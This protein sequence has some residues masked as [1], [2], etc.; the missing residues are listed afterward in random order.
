MPLKEYHHKRHFARTSEPRGKKHTK[1]GSSFVVQKHDASHLHYDFRLE[2]DGVLK[3]WAVPHGPCLDPSQKRL[4]VEVEDHPV[5]YGGFEGTIPAGE[6]G[7]GTV[8]LW[9]RGTWTPHGDPE[10]GYQSGKLKFE[11]H[12]E[13]LHGN[14]DL[15]RMRPR[16]GEKRTNWLLIKEQDSEAVPLA[17]ADILEE[18]PDS[19][20]S[21]RSL[22]QI[23]GSTSAK[24]A[25]RGRATKARPAAKAAS[26]ASQSRSKSTSST[27]KV[28]AG[29]K[30]PF[31]KTVEPELALLVKAPPE[32]SEWLH[33]AKFDGYRIICHLNQ[34][35]VVLRSRNQL[36]WTARFPEIA[37][38][39]QELPA[40]QAVLDGELVSLLPDGTSS[41]QELQMALTAKDTSH[42]KYYVFDLL[43]LDGHDL[44]GLP[45]DERRQALLDLIP[46]AH[47]HPLHFSKELKGT[48]AEAFR[49]ASERGFEGIVSKR[50]A[51]P[52]RSGRTG[53][54]LK[55]KGIQQDEFVIGGFTDSSSDRKELG[56]LLIG[57]YDGNGQFTYCGKVGTG[58][59][60][61]TLRDL[62]KLLA[63][64]E[65]KTNPFD[66]HEEMGS[67]RGVHWVKPTLVG[68]IGYSNWTRDGRL[69]QPVFQGLR[70]DK[71]ARTI[72]RDKPAATTKAAGPRSGEAIEGDSGLHQ[73]GKSNKAK[74]SASNED[75]NI[76]DLVNLTHP[77]RVLFPADG[78]TKLDLASYYAQIS[79][80]ILPHIENRPL[81]LLRCPEG[82]DGTCFYQKHA[83]QGTPMALRRIPI[84]EKHKTEYYLA[85]A[86]LSGLLSL[87]QMS[88]LEIHPWGSRV[89]DIERP[90]RIIFDLDPDP[91]VGWAEVVRA[92]RE[93]RD[94][95]QELRLVSF[96][97]TTGGKGLHVVV[98]LLRRHEW[99]EVKAFTKAVADQIVADS[100]DRYIATLSKAAR[101]GR[102][103]VDYLRNDRG[104]T[105]VAPYS[106]RAREGALVATP[107]SWNELSATTKPADFNVN[108]IPH[109]LASRSSDPW[110]EIG[111]IRQAL[112]APM[113]RKVGL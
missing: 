75:S 81:S 29:K 21:G 78:V 8:L 63:K 23:A 65:L 94:R 72:V 38:A 77:E 36:D 3:S 48:G 61:Q 49:Q 51:Q 85:V 62:H 17:E 33:E 100:P 110:Q 4:A 10:A 60:E 35:K 64:K 26:R 24:R 34:G 98:P 105:A 56:A 7:G 13:K 68:Q 44:R 59:S 66:N 53:D 70:E 31:L 39:V 2:L 42:L 83:G 58:Y 106:T 74:A 76:T 18:H 91:A 20:A 41:F 37:S 97:K 99:P 84:R 5:E 45:L 67:S 19:V 82:H 112:T 52:Y 46:N 43:Y 104:A 79:E 12:G 89:D 55:T 109:R 93:L 11:L 15:I 90:D 6:Y 111:T 92:A 102:I 96:V 22:D 9:D 80:W 32:G 27:S 40:R 54:W 101:K 86:D 108:S 87:V 71:A 113:R 50:R 107:L 95:L 25:T 47:P 103:F 88:I 16:T 14:W 1:Q 30:A 69:R 57:Y 28:D 73:P